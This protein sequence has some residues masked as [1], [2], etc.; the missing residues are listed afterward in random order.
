[1]AKG[2]L[3]S[4]KLTSFAPQAWGNLRVCVFL[5]WCLVRGH[6]KF[7]GCIELVLQAGSS[8]ITGKTLLEWTSRCGKL[9]HFSR[10]R[11]LPCCDPDVIQF[12]TI[13]YRV[14]CISSGDFFH[15]SQ[16]VFSSK[17]VDW[18]VVCLSTNGGTDPGSRHPLFRWRSPTPHPSQFLYFFGRA[19]GIDFPHLIWKSPRYPKLGGASH[20]HRIHIA[21]RISLYTHNCW[22]FTV[23]YVT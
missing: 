6:V 3:S 5:K 13:I 14:L 2:M 17:M 21:W 10:F 11:S 16:Q 8:T 1:M 4:A 7:G 19:G 18:L 23:K 12:I 20:P 22:V 15:Q 9:A